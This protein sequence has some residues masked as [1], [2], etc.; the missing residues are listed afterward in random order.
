MAL[1]FWGNFFLSPEITFCISGYFYKSLINKELNFIFYFSLN[2]EVKTK[3]HNFK[4]FSIE[5]KQF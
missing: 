1:L 4:L 5:L 3:A 2:N